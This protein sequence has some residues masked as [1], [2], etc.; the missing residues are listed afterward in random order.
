[1]AVAAQ[2]VGVV[3]KTKGG[4]GLED[5]R[6]TERM[7]EAPE[8]RF[9]TWRENVRML[10]QVIKNLKSANENQRKRTVIHVQ[11]MSVQLSLLEGN[12]HR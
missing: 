5:L 4:P 3:K 8:A 10:I 6:G 1:M 11:Q 12:P 7:V 9:S 2:V